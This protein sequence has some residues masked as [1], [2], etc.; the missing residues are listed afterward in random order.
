MNFGVSALQEQ[1]VNEIFKKVFDDIRNGFPNLQTIVT[2]Y[3]AEFT[4]AKRGCKHYTAT[5]SKKMACNLNA[6]NRQLLTLKSFQDL[7]K[8]T[9]VSNTSLPGFV[10]QYLVLVQGHIGKQA[11]S[12]Q[13]NSSLM[14]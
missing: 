3:T 4:E 14:H 13:L 12:H 5:S 7:K 9:G 8:V 2:S 1:K 10:F 6:L 11:T